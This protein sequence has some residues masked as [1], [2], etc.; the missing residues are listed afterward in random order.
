[1]D[2]FSKPKSKFCRCDFTARAELYLGPTKETN[3][4]W[5][6]K[7]AALKFAEAVKARDG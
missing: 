4:T 1:M 7:I 6:E 3:E 5:A 2:R